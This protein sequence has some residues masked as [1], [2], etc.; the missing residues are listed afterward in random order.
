MV[1]S[2]L[3]GF[4]TG[5]DGGSMLHF[6]PVWFGEGGPGESDLSVE[7]C[8]PPF[9]VA[10]TPRSVLQWLFS[11]GSTIQ[12]SN[13]LSTPVAG[14][15]AGCNL[16]GVSFAGKTL[17]VSRRVMQTYRSS[18]GTPKCCALSSAFQDTRKAKRAMK[19]ERGKARMLDRGF[20]SWARMAET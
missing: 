3:P 4:A 18:V 12:P 11:R 1:L 2:S 20:G 10:L 19:I 6:L 15:R 16:K 5:P 8:I 14:D 7:T 17:S 9:F 13:A